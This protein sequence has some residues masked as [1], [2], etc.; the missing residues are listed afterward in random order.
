MTEQENGGRLSA[1]GLWTLRGLLQLGGSSSPRELEQHVAKQL[2]STLNPGQIARII[3]N[4][5]LRWA[6]HELRK[7]GLVAGEYGTWELTPAGRA[8]A[9]QRRDESIELP[10]DIEELPPDQANYNGP[11]ESVPVTSFDGF[12][13]PVLRALEGGPLQKQ[14]LL[15][16]I[17]RAVG[18]ALL[19]GDRR[20]MPSGHR[21]WGFRTSWTLTNMKKDG[22]LANEG[23]AIWGL[24]ESGRAR[25]REETGWSLSQFQHSKATVR[26]VGT[27]PGPPPAPPPRWPTAA[28]LELDDELPAR[29][30]E[31]ILR[32]IRP[33]L[34][35]TPALLR[36]SLARNVVLYGPP[37]TGKTHIASRV[38]AALT[39]EVERT[40][41]GAWKLVQFHPSYSYED[42]VQGMRPDLKQSQLRYEM[43]K[44]PFLSLCEVAAEDPDNF[45]VLVIDEINRGDP[46]RIFGELLFALE[47]RGQPV[48]LALGGQLVVPPNVVVIGTMNSVDRSVALVDYALRRRFAF[49][50]LDPEPDA[51]RR[52]RGHSADTKRAALVLGRLNAWLTARL[53]REHVIGHSFFL[54]PVID[55]AQ[56][57]AL[58]AIWQDDLLPLLE[59]YFVGDREALE[60]GRLEW[61]RILSDIPRESLA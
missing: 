10:A 56:P 9:E 46:A 57:G 44:G 24:T 11:T 30:L 41:E 43:R 15:A 36:G 47:Y 37:G 51:I 19:P 2:E 49:V 31:A 22:L 54:N 35:P 18:A 28:W 23:R 12:Q 40:P 6:S 5:Y 58:D 39:E 14:E 55:L 7:S 34:G 3:K 33:E 13:V 32:R 8:T 61:D 27:L 52:V 53:D 17:E 29:A 59:E 60:E 25:L 42:F 4:N 38:A 20:T 21:V 50:R 48:D 16:A 1:W 26:A 45:Y